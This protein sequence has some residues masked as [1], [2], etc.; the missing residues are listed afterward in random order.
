MVGL[1]SL[2]EGTYQAGGGGALI[3]VQGGSEINGLLVAEEDSEFLEWGVL[4]GSPGVNVTRYV[5]IQ[6]YEAPEQANP[7]TP[8]SQGTAAE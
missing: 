7:G 1:S 5:M 8:A 4:I 6:V 3:T 2:S